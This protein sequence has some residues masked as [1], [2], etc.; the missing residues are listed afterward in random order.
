M[1]K[2]RPDDPEIAVG[3]EIR[4]ATAMLWPVRITST[5]IAHLAY[6]TLDDTGAGYR[7]ICPAGQ[8]I[9]P[10]RLELVPSTSRWVWCGAC[11]EWAAAAHIDLPRSG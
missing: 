9:A 6:A 10:E 2:S 5:D 8:L 1:D 3:P 7:P 4:P 11:S